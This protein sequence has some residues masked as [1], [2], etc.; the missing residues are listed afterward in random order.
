MTALETWCLA[1]IGLVFEALLA[2]VVVLFWLFRERALQAKKSLSSGKSK[3]T[4]C[5]YQVMI[6]VRKC[7]VELILRSV[8]T[9]KIAAEERNEIGG[10]SFTFS[11]G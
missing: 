11:F 6:S 2:Y 10:S 5:H 4:Y 9:M 3:L 8:L 7:K 1:M